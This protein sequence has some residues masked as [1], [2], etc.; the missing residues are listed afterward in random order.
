MTSSWLMDLDLEP[1]ERVFAVMRWWDREAHRLRE[2]H[3]RL[4]PPSGQI[5]VGGSHMDPFFCAEAIDGVL[6]SLRI[7]KV[8]SEAQKDGAQRGSYAVYVWNAQRPDAQVHR[9]RH[10]CDSLTEAVIMDVE[11][12]SV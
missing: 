11:K 5:A 3:R 4:S 9:W 12:A 1:R 7:G 10:T 8:P 6:A 2:E